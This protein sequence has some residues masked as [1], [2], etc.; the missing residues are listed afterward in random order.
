LKYSH[1]FCLIDKRT[2]IKNRNPFV[3]PEKYLRNRCRQT[4]CL[5]AAYP[6]KFTIIVQKYLF[7]PNRLFVYTKERILIGFY[8]LVIRF[9]GANN[10]RITTE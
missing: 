4:T 2:S 5:F 10:N 8:V 7:E 9:Y 1:W 6:E 3:K